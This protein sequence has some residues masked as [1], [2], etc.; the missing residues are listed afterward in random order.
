MKLFQIL[1]SHSDIILYEGKFA[2]FRHCVEQAVRDNVRLENADLSN[3]NLSNITLDD[4]FL[5]RANFSNSNLT[6]ANLSEAR[7]HG[8]SFKGTDLYNTCF[9]WSDLRGARFEDASFG[10]TDITG[11]DISHSVFSTLS[12]FSL[13]F[14]LTAL[15]DGCV[16][17]NHDGIIAT[18]SKPPVVIR[19][20][21]H[22]M[23][24]F[25]DHCM[26]IDHDVMDY[27]SGIALL[28]QR[29]NS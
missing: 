27:Q 3:R 15:M 6:G 19:G 26:K 28:K 18:M 7:L 9:A 13:D 4:A 22:N 14:A 8:A 23:I 2:K 5:S 24:I 12:C 25:M 21:S 16:F 29:N 11:S 17:T 1:T 10:G 20:V